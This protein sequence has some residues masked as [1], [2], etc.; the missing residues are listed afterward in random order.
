MCA[1]AIE[2]WLM[3]HSETEH[4]GGL[5][6]AHALL[7]MEVELLMSCKVVEIDERWQVEVVQSKLQEAYDADNTEQI[8]KLLCSL[9]RA[10][11]APELS[12]APL[13]D[14]TLRIALRQEERVSLPMASCVRLA[15]LLACKLDA[16]GGLSY[17]YN[18]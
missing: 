17:I 6:S 4:W 13:E 9:V 14:V 2:K 10:V 11:V 18:V 8:T 16:L 1:R 3:G 12:T 5:A 7:P 15:R